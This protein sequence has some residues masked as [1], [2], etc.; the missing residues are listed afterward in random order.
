MTRQELLNDLL[1]MGAGEE[2]ELRCD[3]GDY[4]ITFTKGDYHLKGNTNGG[5]EG[6]FW[7]DSTT[8]TGPETWLA[9]AKVASDYLE[10]F[11][12]LKCSWD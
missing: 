10:D 1:D 3:N 12:L 8:S 6:E 7:I 4:Y 11:E 2:S 5:F 9:N